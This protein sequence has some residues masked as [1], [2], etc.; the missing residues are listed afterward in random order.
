MMFLSVL[1]ALAICAG[2]MALSGGID[3][4]GWLILASCGGVAAIIVIIGTLFAGSRRFF[5][6]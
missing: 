1:L 2:I 4:V 5:K 6:V 3:T